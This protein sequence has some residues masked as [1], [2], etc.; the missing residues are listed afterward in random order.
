MKVKKK[1][2]KST[3]KINGERGNNCFQK[4]CEI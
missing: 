4:A 2:A 3:G 1:K